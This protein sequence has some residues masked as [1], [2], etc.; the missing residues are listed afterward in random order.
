[1]AHKQG[2]KTRKEYSTV[3]KTDLQVAKARVERKL[4]LPNCHKVFCLV[5]SYTKHFSKDWTKQKCKTHNQNSAKTQHQKYK[6]V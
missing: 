1:M 3:S 2:C 4:L 5:L 6:V